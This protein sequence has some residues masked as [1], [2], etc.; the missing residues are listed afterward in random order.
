M[1]KV[2]AAVTPARILARPATNPKAALLHVLGTTKNVGSSYGIDV[3]RLYTGLKSTRRFVRDMTTC[4]SY[5]Y[6]DLWAAR[7]IYLRKPGAHLDIGSRIDGF[8]AY[9]LVFMDVTLVET[10]EMESTVEGLHFV[11]ADATAMDVFADNSQDSLSSLHAAEHF[12]LGRYGDP[13][14]SDACFQFIRNLQRILKLGGRSYFSVPIGRE[15]LVFNAQWIFFLITILEAFDELSLVSFSTVTRGGNFIID[16]NPND[17][18][19]KEY[20]LDSSSFPSGD[21]EPTRYPYSARLH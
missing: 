14:D 2:P 20:G 17:Y 16:A 15:R 19:D 7:K 6:Q 11:K 5:F 18:P 3:S 9:L 8:I 4:G 12:G 1:P 21:N 13:V 10:R